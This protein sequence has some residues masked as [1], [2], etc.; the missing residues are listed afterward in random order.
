M[1]IRLDATTTAAVLFSAMALLNAISGG[2][3][4]ELS[5]GQ[6]A[7]A[8][9]AQNESERVAV[10]SCRENVTI[11]HDVHW[12][13]A[14]MVNPGDDSTECTLPDDRAGNLNAARWAAEDHCVDEVRRHTWRAMR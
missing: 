10:E 7:R 4:L 2:L 1:R 8:R 5:S 14:C 6:S 11:I 9:V 3:G 13:A 12:A